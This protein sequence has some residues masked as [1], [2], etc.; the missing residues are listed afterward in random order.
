MYCFKKREIKKAE[1]INL[2]ISMAAAMMQ[3]LKQRLQ[4]EVNSFG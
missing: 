1:H 3:L 2:F 4:L